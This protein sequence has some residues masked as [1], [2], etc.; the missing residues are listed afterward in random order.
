LLGDRIVSETLTAQR[1]HVQSGP[2]QRAAADTAR[3]IWPLKLP[4]RWTERWVSATYA[5]GD[6]MG[7]S[8]RWLLL[9]AVIGAA[10]LLLDCATG[11]TIHRP[12]TA[13]LLT[14]LLL[15]AVVRDAHWLGF[16]VMVT[17]FAAHSALTIALAALAPEC[18]AGIL[19]D[20]MNYWQRSRDWIV[21]GVSEE[22]DLQY[23]LP[24]HFEML[25]AMVVFSYT[26]LGL[27]LFWEGLYQVD[28]MNCYVGRLLAESQN[29]WVAVGVG[30]HPWSVCRGLGYMILAFEVVSISWE[31]LT[32]RRLSTAARRRQR[33]LAGLF[34]LGLD[35]LLKWSCL[36]N[37]REVLLANLN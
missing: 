2:Q 16:G 4:R 31:R 26:S 1:R 17:A 10:P 22:Y 23:W 14:P 30:W 18:L 21:T 20:G 29:P 19:P 12:V 28:L 24:A 36:E 37:V 34:F 3:W 7:P 13:L 35:G 6:A 33:W 15:A 25:L 27:I 32:G 11:W 5:L 8:W 9:S